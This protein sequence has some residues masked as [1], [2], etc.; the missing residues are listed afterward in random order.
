VE[1][2]S[3]RTTEPAMGFVVTNVELSGSHSGVSH[4]AQS[5]GINS[6]N[7]AP[8]HQILTPFCVT[9]RHFLPD[10]DFG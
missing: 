7:K 1:T 6:M 5:D 3:K 4:M 8:Y 10:I 2:E 9:I